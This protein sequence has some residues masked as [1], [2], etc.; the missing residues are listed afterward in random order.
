[1]AFLKVQVETLEKA[2]H[3]L[4]ETDGFLGEPLSLLMTI[5]GYGFLSAASVWA[6]TD[7]FALLERGRDFY[8]CRNCPEPFEA[9]SSIHRRERISK[10]GNAH[11]SRTAY[12]AAL[13]AQ[14]SKSRM[15]DF[16]HYIRAEGQ[17]PKAAL[18]ALERKLLRTGLAVVK[19]GQPYQK[20]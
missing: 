9:G 10:T 16:Y 3:T 6:Q 14:R 19:S 20:A 15:D 18:V 8:L 12:L 2:V 4:K 7:G 1:M 13:G 11:L 5:P 17:P